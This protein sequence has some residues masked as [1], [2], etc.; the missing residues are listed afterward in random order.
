MIDIAILGAAGR[1]GQRLVVLSRNDGNFT[2]SSAI[3]RPDHPSLNK[4]VGE[5]AGIGPINV[6]LSADLRTK[7]QLLI[8]FTTPASMRHW[9]GICRERSIAMLIGTTGLAPSDHALV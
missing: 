6:P 1:M 3:E 8:D 2:L 5:I 7:P 9:L 4:D